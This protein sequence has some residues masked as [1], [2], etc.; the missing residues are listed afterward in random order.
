M[1]AVMKGPKK[2]IS[3]L[4]KTLVANVQPFLVNLV[5]MKNALNS[6][7]TLF[8]YVNSAAFG[9]WE[10]TLGVSSRTY[11]KESETNGD[12]EVLHPEFN[13]EADKEMIYDKRKTEASERERE[14]ESLR[15]H[16]S[17]TVKKAYTTVSNGTKPSNR[18]QALSERTEVQHEQVLVDWKK[19]RNSPF[20]T[21]QRLKSS[22]QK[23]GF[24]KRDRRGGAGLILTYLL[25]QLSVTSRNVL[26]SEPTLPK[27]GLLDKWL[28]FQALVLLV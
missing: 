10:D 19:Q 25:L 6:M 21:H 18:Q 13:C 26:Y 9:L 5:T 3:P 8:M 1:G 28:S 24:G 14:R 17:L 20:G 27:M 7:F 11:M 23:C 4:Y 12:L 15:E 2:S 22:K 16:I